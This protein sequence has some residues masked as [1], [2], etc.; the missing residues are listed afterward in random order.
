M[1][2]PI[3]LALQQ[4]EVISLIKLYPVEMIGYNKPDLG[5]SRSTE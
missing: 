5:F 2:I 4:F 1:K 3:Y